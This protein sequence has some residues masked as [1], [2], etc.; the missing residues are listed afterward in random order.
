LPPSHIVSR[1]SKYVPGQRN[2]SSMQKKLEN[3]FRHYLD[4]T[5]YALSKAATKALDRLIGLADPLVTTFREM[6]EV[7]YEFIHAAIGEWNPLRQAKKMAR[8]AALEELPWL[9]AQVARE[10]GDEA[11]AKKA[12]LFAV[13]GSRFGSSRFRNLV[14]GGKDALLNQ[15]QKY[16]SS[17][18]SL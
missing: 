15:F 16:R 5:P 1:P 4:G 10:T 14:R 13:T 18:L 2:Y 6:E 3:H 11:Q 7:V 12:L 8:E 9:D 17:P